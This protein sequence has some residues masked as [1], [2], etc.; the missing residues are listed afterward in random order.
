MDWEPLRAVLPDPEELGSWIWMYVPTRR[1]RASPSTTTSTCGRGGTSGWIGWGGATPRIRRRVPG[2]GRGCGTALLV[3]LAVV[4]DGMENHLPER[5]GLPEA[6]RIQVAVPV[7]DDGRRGST[8]AGA[9][10][11]LDDDGSPW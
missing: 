1:P 11:G 8:V 2:G 9:V 7:G 3:G 10:D 4:F 5:I 6:V